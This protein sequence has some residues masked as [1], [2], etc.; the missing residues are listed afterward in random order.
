[1]KRWISTALMLV[2]CTAVVRADV[3]IT[4]STS[5]EGGPAAMSGAPPMPKTTTRIKGL[6]QR[7]DLEIAGRSFST[8]VDLSTKQVAILQHAEK[9]VQILS[10]SADAVR[11]QIELPKMDASMEPSG[12]SQVIDGVSCD[13]YLFT[14]SVDMASVGGGAAQMP[15]EAAAMMQGVTMKMKGSVWVSKSAPGAGEYSAFMAAASKANLTSLVS[16]AVS[17]NNGSMER[18]MNAMSKLNGLGYMTDMTM[19]F[20]GTGQFVDM[21]KQMGEMH[22]TSKV[23]SISTEPIDDSIFVIP[24]D[25]TVIK[26]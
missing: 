24:S 1:M 10:G 18:M 22:V 15:P 13:E 3:T 5:I 6:K 11:P 12:R 19:S 17:G 25:Y 20:D 23:T 2:V 16:G 8:I 9:T 7:T 14:T 21:M 26:K 4:Q